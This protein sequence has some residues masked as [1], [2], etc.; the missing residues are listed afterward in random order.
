MRVLVIDHHDS[1]VWNLVHLIAGVL[2]QMPDVVEHDGVVSFDGYTHVVLS[3]GPGHP[4]NP[5]DF[6]LRGRA[7]E[8]DLAVLGVCLGM[9][10]LVTHYGGTVEAIEPAHGVVAQVTH[11]SDPLFVDI[12]ATFSAV[13][14]H[15]LAAVAL[16]EDL[17]ATA[18]SQGV[19][20]A[21]RHVSRPQLGVQFHPESILS[22]FGPRLI[23][24][25]LEGI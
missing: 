24:N 1:Y 5:R 3:P 11:G 12:P 21:V 23:A 7:F 9:Q 16:P 14:Y 2:G 8:H 20:M 4:A 15:S 22:Q 17:I 25:F 19:V 18:W 13:R 6:A 10:G